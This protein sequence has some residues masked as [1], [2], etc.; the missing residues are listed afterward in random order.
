MQDGACPFYAPALL[1]MKLLLTLLRPG[2]TLVGDGSTALLAAHWL[3]PDLRVSDLG[4]SRGGYAVRA[5]ALFASLGLHALAGGPR[6]L[7]ETL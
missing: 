7:L 3:R 1:P 4:L 2:T 5:R 6:E